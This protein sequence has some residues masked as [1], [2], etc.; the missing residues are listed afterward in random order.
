MNDGEATSI[1]VARQSTST[2]AVDRVIN[3]L[4]EVTL[5]NIEQLVHSLSQ[6]VQEEV[7]ELNDENVIVLMKYA[8]EIV[9]LQQ[10]DG[11]NK[12]QMALEMVRSYVTESNVGERVKETLNEVLFNGMGDRIVELLVAASKGEIKI[13]INELQEQ[14]TEEIAVVVNDTVIRRVCMWFS[15]ILKRN[16]QTIQVNETSQ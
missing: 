3:E 1:S 4:E 15:R 9:E 8:M 12:K 5:V 2:Q 14:V 10:M 11:E 6:K 16:Q 7:V 13:N